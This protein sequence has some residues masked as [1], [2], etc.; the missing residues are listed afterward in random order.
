M[1]SLTKYEIGFGK[2]IKGKKSQWGLIKSLDL[3]YHTIIENEEEKSLVSDKVWFEINKDLKRNVAKK[4]WVLK[5][6]LD[7]VYIS[8]IR[9]QRR[10]YCVLDDMWI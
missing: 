2:E 4:W 8:M 7:L 3:K 9:H 10:K 1:T 5:Q 6:S